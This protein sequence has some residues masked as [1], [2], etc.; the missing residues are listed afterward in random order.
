MTAKS[1]QHIFLLMKMCIGGPGSRTHSL[2]RPPCL[3]SQ[4]CSWVVPLVLEYGQ[5]LLIRWA[6]APQK[7]D[8]R[9]GLA[10]SQAFPLQAAFQS[11]ELLLFHSGSM[12]PR[13]V[14]LLQH[15]TAP[16]SVYVHNI[17]VSRS[18]GKQEERFPFTTKR[19]KFDSRGWCLR[20]VVT[21][22]ACLM[23]LSHYATRAF[24]K[25]SFFFLFFFPAGNPGLAKA[26][27]T[28]S[29]NHSQLH[30]KSEKVSHPGQL[31]VGSF[32][33]TDTFLIAPRVCGCRLLLWWWLSF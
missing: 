11:M 28:L 2:T 32:K 15:W 29:Q 23:V 24:E 22:Y 12:W 21:I 26:E 10:C 17:V 19:K 14:L 6:V 5:K 1:W 18:T 20:W 31:A 7:E 4:E 16:V 30:K 3:N 27:N 13:L 25:R 33:S 9:K 8:R